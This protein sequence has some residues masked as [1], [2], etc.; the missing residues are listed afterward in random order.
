MRA[1]RVVVFACLCGV[2]LYGLDP[3]T[4]ARNDYFGN[5]WQLASFHIGSSIDFNTP[6]GGAMGINI[7]A[8]AGKNYVFLND[9]DIGVRAKY[10]YAKTAV[11]THS[12]GA[13]LYV[14][15]WN[16]PNAGL[17]SFALGGGML[18]AHRLDSSVFGGYIEVGV[19]LFK[20]FPVNADLLYCASFYP[21]NNPLAMAEMTHGIHIVFGFF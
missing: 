11:S 21:V 14:H 15:S 10:L 8:S 6:N 3:Q 12:L 19:A 18:A 2:K 13:M 20:F 1:F 5:W 7:G 17:F 4:Q 16:K 9:L